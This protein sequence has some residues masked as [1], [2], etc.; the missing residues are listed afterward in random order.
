MTT[1]E[2]QNE[3][4]DKVGFSRLEIYNNKMEDG[5]IWVFITL[6]AMKVRLSAR[7]LAWANRELKNKGIAIIG[8]DGVGHE[9]KSDFYFQCPSSQLRMYKKLS[10][11]TFANN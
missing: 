4:Y 9:C 5:R 1:N 2:L 8:Y 6:H 11:A 3:F 10:H 7:N